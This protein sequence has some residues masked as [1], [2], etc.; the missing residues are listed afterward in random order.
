MLLDR[1]YSNYFKLNNRGRESKRK[2]IIFLLVI[3]AIIDMMMYAYIN[4][5]D[6]KLFLGLIVI[7][8]IIIIIMFV[9][10]IK[11]STSKLKV[12]FHTIFQVII[13]CFFNTVLTLIASS[14]FSSIE[15]NYFIKCAWFFVLFCSNYY[16]I[17]TPA[18]NSPAIDNILKVTFSLLFVVHL[19]P[20]ISITMTGKT[21]RY[22][23]IG[24]DYQTQYTFSNVSLDNISEKIRCHSSPENL[25][26]PLEVILDIGK[27]TYVHLQGQKK[28]YSFPKS[29]IVSQYFNIDIENPCMSIASYKKQSHENTL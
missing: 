2:N 4:D 28:V 8:I 17:I 15:I 6:Y 5:F 25:S 24:G 29:I 7:G 22:L 23:K 20:Y 10:I 9:F 19:Y 13:L 27:N 11:T 1:Y 16:L 12:T 3:I 18:T 14:F 21:L 26:L